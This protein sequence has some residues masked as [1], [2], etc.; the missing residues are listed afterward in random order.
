MTS[1]PSRPFKLFL[2]YA[3]DNESC[4]DRLK[5]NL[6]P[7]VRNHWVELWDDREISAG[8][9]WRAE[10]DGAMTSADAAVFLLDDDFLASDFCMDVEVAS[11]LQRHREDGT[12][13]L[14]VVTDHCGW[15]DFDYIKRFK[16]IPL[17]GRPITTYRPY[18][19]A[20]THIKDEIGN[21]LARH[22]PKDPVTDGGGTELADW[23]GSGVPVDV[24]NAFDLFGTDSSA[25]GE[26]DS[27]VHPIEPLRP[28]R[29]LAPLPPI[30]PLTALQGGYRSL[31][32]TLPAL[33][34]KLPGRSN[35][36]F[37]RD[38]ELALLAQWQGRKGV[39]VWVADGG[40]GKSTLVR[41]WLQTQQWP[42]GTRFLGHSFYR[43]GNRN[44][45]ASARGFLVEALQQLHVAHAVDAPDDTLG[46]LL[47]E[48][49]AK[50]PT[51]LVLD[52]IEPLQESADGSPHNGR[53]RDNGLAALLE[54][55]ARQPG[56]ALCIASSRLPVA[57]A[58]IRDVQG[59]CEQ[60]LPTLP[61]P[62]A[63]ALLR[64]RGLR[65]SDAE[66]ARMAERCGHH[67]LTL[68]LAAEFCHTYLQ[69][70]AAA[71]L[72]RPWKP[73]AG[74]THAATVM[75]WFDESL[76]EEHQ[77]LDR[78]LALILG[79]FDRPAPWGALLALRAKEP[80][81]PGLTECLH[82][83]DQSALL[84]S[85][86]RLAQWGLLQ[87]DLTQE[88][89]ELDAHPLVREYF[90]TQVQSQAPEVWRAAHT[91]LFKWFKALP[92]KYY[93]E[94]LEEM[95]PLYRAVRHGCQ[96]G[97]HQRACEDVYVARILR[98]TG[99]GGF[100][101]TK[102]LGAFG[103]DLDAVACFFDEPWLRPVGAL[104]ENVQAWLLNEAAFSLRALGRLE[105]ALQPMLAGAQMQAGSEDWT[106]AAASYGSLSELHLSLGLVIAAVAT[107]RQSVDYA[108]RSGYAFQQ[109]TS[110]T[111]LADALHQKGE[112]AVALARFLE[113]EAMQGRIQ[114][115]YPLL[116]S[117]QGFQ[118]CELLL[119][120]AER[121][122]WRGPGNLPLVWCCEEVIERG[123][124]MFE[125]RTPGD[126]P[127]GIAL[128][129]LTLARSVLYAALLQGEMPDAGKAVVDLAVSGLRAAGQQQFV[130]H[131]LLTRAWLRHC[132]GGLTGAQADLAEAEQ[133]TARGGMRLFQ[134]DIHLTRAR[135][136]RDRVELAKAR[137][138]IEACGYGRRL[139]ELEDAEA[140]ARQWQS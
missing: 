24:E 18:S 119:A 65:G 106:K 59:F 111:S 85:L 103:A 89:P 3:H 31:K 93:P 57:D 53:I 44:E 77:A 96:A 33:L 87:A 133:I 45:S 51:V 32:L 78:E 37:G 63:Q 62:A 88:E 116:Y 58:A 83:S 125:W 91:V 55:L 60:T 19:K 95:E 70:Q 67:A 54:S 109:M 69:A 90:G 15:E 105:E 72:A 61:P 38:D 20:Y 26:Q 9:A 29:P 136:F 40:T 11:F 43:Q 80:P 129:H 128:D 139:P 41:W 79:L 23:M 12:L 75:A 39:F 36:L 34:E 138:L 127:L 52:G 86:A 104:T 28:I 98:G 131:A 110:R 8:A 118:Y 7:L 16:V 74:Q 76:A 21:A 49:I 73:L 84:E 117:L 122:A 30:P 134:A 101:G 10:I 35:H 102:M 100:Y 50:Q 14:F 71:F 13:I 48:E 107:A 124:R 108:D 126:S 112:A 25:D 66:L 123:Q 68:V 114:P 46:G 82:Q 94:T 17:D 22:R 81:I 1:P 132:L 27:S 140:A 56:Q 113:A 42:V 92:E 97:L 64:Q 137:V 121:A 2:S 135:L 120:G 115:E 130:P 99:R 4:K 5:I 47:A 6:A